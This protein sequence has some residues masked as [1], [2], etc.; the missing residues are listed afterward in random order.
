VFAEPR[1]DLDLDGVERPLLG[2][3]ARL[4]HDRGHGRSLP[5]QETAQT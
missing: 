1:L 5:G 4:Y 2:R 3:L